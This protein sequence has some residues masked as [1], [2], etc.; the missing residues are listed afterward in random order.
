M[1]HFVTLIDCHVLDHED[2]CFSNFMAVIWS[3]FVLWLESVFIK[4]VLFIC[5][6]EVGKDMT[7]NNSIIVGR[8]WP[9]LGI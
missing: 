6:K 5:Q 9:F 2:K 7:G 1:Q 4:A 8:V 3:H